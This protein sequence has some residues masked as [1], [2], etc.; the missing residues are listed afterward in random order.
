MA[1]PA[2]TKYSV[3]GSPLTTSELDTNFQNLQDATVSITAGSGGTAVSTDLNGNI[4]LVA[5]TGVTLTGD[6]TAKTITITNDS[7]GSNSFS[8]IAVAGQSNV[9]AD[10]V[11]DTLTLVAGTNV[12]IT[13]NSSTDTITIATTAFGTVPISNGLNNDSESIAI[14]TNAL[15]STISNS[16]NIAIGF[17][18]LTALTNA[19]GYNVA[20]GSGALRAATTCDSNVGIGRWAGYEVT[21]GDYNVQIG[22]TSTSVTTATRNVLVGYATKSFGNDNTLIGQWA[23]LSNSGGGVSGNENTILGA[24]AGRITGGINGNNNIIIGYNADPT[25]S[26]AA[27][28]ITLGDTN[29]S[30]FRIP[31][32]KLRI[33]SGTITTD[34]ASDLVLNTNT[35]TNSGNITIANGVNGNITIATNGTGS[36]L[37]KSDTLVLG[38]L[39]DPEAVITTDGAT[40]LLLDTN[41][42]TNSGTISI[43][44]GAD[45]DIE[46][47]PNGTGVVYLNGALK[48]NATTG[49]PTDDTTPVT[50]LAVDIGGSTYYIPGYQ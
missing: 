26:S 37:A 45:G 12:S 4:T 30:A 7:L 39:T 8:T 15:D 18:A 14:G 36:V 41:D 22:H 34:T 44:A 42:G 33:T 43:T 11:S 19:N 5:G 24:S 17:N 47:A 2:I 27:N 46:I 40:N 1:K 35:G 16:E 23:G 48:T 50:W 3:K 13:T 6:N 28:E 32:I 21:T 29:I 25:S 31:G 20:V 49:T 10:T 9:V 38:A